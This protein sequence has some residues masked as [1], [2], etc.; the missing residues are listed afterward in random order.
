MNTKGCMIKLLKD[1]VSLKFLIFH[2]IKEKIKLIFGM[3]FELKKHFQVFLGRVE[4][5]KKTV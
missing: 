2:F 5:F 3:F 1:L 4:V